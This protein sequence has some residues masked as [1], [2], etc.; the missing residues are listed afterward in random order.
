MHYDAIHKTDLVTYVAG[1]EF[2]K[3]VTDLAKAKGEAQQYID[4]L[5]FFDITNPVAPQ[6]NP[7]DTTTRGQ[8]ASFLYKTSNVE[9]PMRLL[10]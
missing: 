3:D 8:F 5:D 7:K 6:F 4:V 1:Q 9:N 2:N 10:K